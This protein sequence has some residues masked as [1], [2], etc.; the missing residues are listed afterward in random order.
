MYGS[1]FFS[2]APEIPPTSIE[3][4]DRQLVAAC[5]AAFEILRARGG[6][7]AELDAQAPVPPSSRAL[8]KRLPRARA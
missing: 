1:S 7:L 3:E 6:T 8:L 2:T 4:H 5:R